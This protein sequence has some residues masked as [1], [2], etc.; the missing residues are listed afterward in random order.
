MTTKKAGDFGNGIRKRT[1]TERVA[2]NSELLD[3]ICSI[4]AIA[5]SPIKRIRKT[6]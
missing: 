6:I 4:R 1:K 2:K 3:G 5:E